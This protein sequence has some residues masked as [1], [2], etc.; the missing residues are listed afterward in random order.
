MF[1]ISSSILLM[2]IILIGNVFQRSVM[3]NSWTFADEVGRFLVIILTFIGASYAAR[4]GRHIRMS[5]IYDLMPFKIRKV[6]MILITA[7]TSIVLMIV[8]YYALLY[9]IFIIENGRVSNALRIPMY[10]VYIFVPIGLA[11]T[12]LQYFLTMITNI[13]EEDVYVSTTKKDSEVV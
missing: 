10:Y 5:A 1:I 7:I 12:S 8:A 4:Q 2:S 6:L 13:V 3:N 11:L 9:T